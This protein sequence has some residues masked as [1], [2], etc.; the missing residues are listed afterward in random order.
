MPDSGH[1]PES[2]WARFVESLWLRYSCRM[3]CF[4]VVN[5]PNLQIWPQEN[6]A[7]RV[8]GMIATVDAIARRHEVAVTCLAPSLSDA[9]SDRPLMITEQRPF[10]AALLDSLD[11][12]G[13]RGGE[14]WVWSFHNYNDAELGGD[15]VSGM[16]AQLSGRWRG[17]S[18]ADGGP[19]VYATEGGVRLTGVTRRHGARCPLRGGAPSRRR[20]WPTR[21]RATSERRGSG[22]SP[23]TPSRPTP[24]TTAGCARPTAR[25]G[26]PSTPSYG[27]VAASPARAP[28]AAST[29]GGDGEGRLAS[30]L[31]I[32]HDA[33]AD[34]HLVAVPQPRLAHALPV[35]EDAVEAAVVGDHRSALALEHERVPAG[36]GAVVDHDV[37]G[38]APADAGEPAEPQDDD[39]VAVGD[40]EVAARR[41]PPDGYGRGANPVQQGA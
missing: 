10:T 27:D 13:F 20:C 5:E 36:D 21:S 22:C 28:E 18:A 3:A 7:E 2:P 30:N 29:G 6:V 15:R 38:G 19:L 41:E 23:S 16:R 8:A 35:D 17:R 31:E 12:R 34:P 24:P 26:R 1:G 37:G 14:R 25:R 40:R 9:E 4:E 33:I 11:R 32:A 39:V